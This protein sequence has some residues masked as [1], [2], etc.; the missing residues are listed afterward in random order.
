MTAALVLWLEAFNAFLL[1]STADGWLL[2]YVADVTTL[3]LNASTCW[4]DESAIPL[5]LIVA[6]VVIVAIVAARFLVASFRLLAANLLLVALALA[7]WFL[8]A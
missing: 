1:T 4:F 3:L 8:T 5:W 7:S 6:S 2:T